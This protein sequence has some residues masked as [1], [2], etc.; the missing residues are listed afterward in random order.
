MS[1]ITTPFEKHIFVCTS[2]EYCP[3]LDGN[4]KEIHQAFKEAVAKAG[5]KGKVRVNN[6]GCLDQCGHG[7][8]AVVYPEGVWYSHLTLADVPV[9][10]EEHLRN[11]QPV[12][13][14][15]YH[16][17]NSG[18]NKLKRGAD[19]RRIAGQVDGCRADWPAIPG[20]NPDDGREEERSSSTEI[21]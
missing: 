3:M 2:G 11:G 10:V 1:D 16:P 13:R 14:L 12:E 20:Q 8:S 17:P 5:L 9:I 15:R 18:A 4:S 6:S 21:G 7:P 19:R